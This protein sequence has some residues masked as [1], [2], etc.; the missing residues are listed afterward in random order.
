MNNILYTIAVLLLISW[1]IGYFAFNT[2]GII[3]ILFV[4]AIIAVLLRIISGNKIIK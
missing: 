4:I 1:A 3:H 2:G